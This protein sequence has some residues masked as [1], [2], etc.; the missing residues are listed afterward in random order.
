MAFFKASATISSLTLTSRVFGFVRDVLLAR[1]LGASA[2]ADAFFVA[3]RL[4]NM[5]RQLFAEGAFNVA[6]VPFL[7]HKTAQQGSQEGENFAGVVFGWVLVLVLALTVLGMVFM[8]QVVLLIAPGFADDPGTAALA[9]DLAR[10]TLPYF[11]FIV[12]TSFMG[13]V[14]HTQHRFAAFAA[15]PVLLNGAFI[16]CLLLLPGAFALPVYAAAIAVPLGGV[17]QVALMA[18]AVKRSGFQLKI[19]KP[20]A[21]PDLKPL[22]RKIGPTFV[23]VGAQQINTFLTTVL[24]SL[25]MPGSISYLFYADRLNQLPLALVGIALATAML[26]TLSKAF[27]NGPA[28]K[29]QKLLGQGLS[30]ALALGLA[31]GAGLCMLAYE[32]LTVLFVRGAFDA[33]DAYLT[34]LALMAFAV[35]LP[36]FILVKVTSGAF[37]ARGNTATPVKTALTS[38]AVNIALMLLLMPHYG[39][40]GLAIAA[41]AAGWCHLLLQLY[42]MQ[43]QGIV[44]QVFWRTLMPYTLKA[45]GVTLLMVAL[46]ALIKTNLPLPE[47]FGQQLLW[48][49]L[50]ISV[51]GFFWLALAMLA[52]LH[53]PFLTFAAP[54]STQHQQ[55][56]D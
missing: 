2:M 28:E 43:R 9:T 5:L 4:P 11:V 34:S 35:G 18:V 55:R 26:P 22:A 50:T 47:A 44:G 15:A 32:V 36:A 52:K 3:L 30:V 48:L 51:G 17:L 38:I 25:L 1:L 16:G 56:Q 23:G 49:V 24:A 45:G 20:Q 29:A 14:L 27:K 37:Y 46:L 19:K 54:D 13:G 41:A 42:L 53:R 12:A 33:G 7:T 21:H 39:H 6:F 31:A 10:V 40:V 8:P